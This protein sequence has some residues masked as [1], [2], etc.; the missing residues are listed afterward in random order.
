[1]PVVSWQWRAFR[2]QRS[3]FSVPKIV[4]VIVLVLDSAWRVTL[5]A[6]A[7]RHAFSSKRSF[8]PRN[9]PGRLAYSK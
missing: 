9:K 6:S 5:W 2:V 3:E 4:L 1:V 7:R 8:F